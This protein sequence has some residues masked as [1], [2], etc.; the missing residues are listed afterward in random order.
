MPKIIKVSIAFV[1]KDE[2]MN[3]GSF[4]F[5]CYKPPLVGL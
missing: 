2:M 4:L 1:D 3:N 5:L